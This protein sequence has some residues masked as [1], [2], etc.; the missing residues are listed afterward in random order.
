[1]NQLGN[2]DSALAMEAY[3]A[4]NLKTLPSWGIV[5]ALAFGL[6]ITVMAYATGEWCWLGTFT[7]LPFL[8]TASNQPAFLHCNC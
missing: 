1:M 2:Y 3:I 8:C 6:G 7:L 5:T 4:R